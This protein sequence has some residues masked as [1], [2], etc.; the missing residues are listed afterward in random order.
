MRRKKLPPDK[1]LDWRD[2]NMPVLRPAMTEGDTEYKPYEFRA[3]WIQRYHQHA[4]TAPRMELMWRDDPSY[5]WAR[6]ERK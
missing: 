6:D 5:F 4:M 3:D 2:P 1:R